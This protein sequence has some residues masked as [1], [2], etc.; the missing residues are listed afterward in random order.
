MASLQ[1]LNGIKYGMK[2]NKI[3]ISINKKIPFFKLPCTDGTIMDIAKIKNKKI[4]LYFYPRNDTPG[5]TKQA[6]DFTK[7]NLLIKKNNCKIFGIS[8]DSIDSHYCSISTG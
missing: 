7:L 1:T 6:N 3:K 5:C 4:I 8:K 2:M